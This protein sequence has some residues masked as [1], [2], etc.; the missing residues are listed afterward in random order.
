LDR[1]G[2]KDSAGIDRLKPVY[3]ELPDVNPTSALPIPSPVVPPDNVHLSNAP[4]QYSSKDT[5]QPPAS[6]VQSSS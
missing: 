3:L 4:A 1:S 6:P 5:V 2:I